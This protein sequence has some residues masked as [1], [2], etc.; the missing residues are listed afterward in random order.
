MSVLVQAYTRRRRSL[1]QGGGTDWAMAF[2]ESGVTSEADSRVL[3]QRL[4]VLSEELCP[5]LHGSLRNFLVRPFGGSVS[6]ESGLLTRAYVVQ[7]GGA[8]TS[9]KVLLKLRHADWFALED[10][11]GVF[12]LIQSQVCAGDAEFLL[13]CTHTS[14]VVIST[15]ALHSESSI[16]VAELF[17]GGFAGWSQAAY[18]LHRAGL[19]LHLKWSLDVDSDCERMLQVQTP[20]LQCIN[21]ASELDHVSDTSPSAL[22]VCANLNWDWWLRMF[23]IRPVHIVTL[24]PPCQPWSAAGTGSGLDAADGLLL[25]RAIDI[26]GAFQTP[27]VALEQVSGFLHHAH[28]PQIMQAWR[29]AGYQVQWQASL[30]LLDVLPSSRVRLIMVFRHCTCHGP[31]ALAGIN[32]TVAQRQNLAMAKVIFDLPAEL[33]KPL[34]LTEEQK[35]VYFDPWYLP[36]SR[37]GSQHPQRVENFRVRTEAGV[38]GCFLAQYQFQHELPE[39]QLASKGLLGFLLRHKGCLRFFAGA[40]VAAVHGAVRPVWL[41]DDRRAQM[42]MLGNAIAVPHAAAGLAVACRAL[43]RPNVP[44]PPAAVAKCLE[45]RIRND[46]A[47]FLP[48]GR[49]WVLCRKD[50][51]AEVITSGVIPQLPPQQPSAPP[52]FATVSLLQGRQTMTIRVPAGAPALRV[53]R[54]LGV[55]QYA[56][57]LPT[58]VFDCLEDVSLHVPSLPALHNQGF[59]AEAASQD[60][61]CTVLAPTAM[62]VVDMASPRLWPQ[63]LN[64]FDSLTSDCEE[65]CCWSPS[66]CRI[67][68][69]EDFGPCVVATTQ[70]SE[71][72]DLPMH[73]L[74]GVLPRMCE[75]QSEGEVRLECP[76]SAAVDAWLGFPFHLAQAFGWQSSVFNFP[77]QDGVP[78]YIGLQP[79]QLGHLPH[80]QLPRQIRLWYLVALLDRQSSAAASPPVNVE[81]QVDSHRVWWGT[82]PDSLV[83]EEVENWWEAVSLACK[84]PPGARVFSGPHPIPSGDTIADV[85]QQPKACVVRRSGHLLLTIHPNCVGGGVK[86]ENQHWAQTRAASL[87]LSQGLDLTATTN[88]VDAIAQKGSVPKLMQCLQALAEDTRW[89]QLCAYA[90]ELQIPVPATTNLVARAEGRARRAF[91][92]K[93]ANAAT[94]PKAAEVTVDPG[95]FLNADDT[96]APIL[97]HIRPGATG[98]LLVDPDQAVDAL[99]T[100]KGVQP[101]ELGLLVLGHVC[102]DSSTCTRRVSFPATSRRCGSKLLLAGCLHN[103]GGKAIRPNQKSDITV[104][105]PATTC[106]VF[107]AFADEFAA[108]AW[109]QLVLAPV[110]HMLAAFQDCPAVKAVLTPWGRQFRLKDRPSSP[111][112]ADQVSFQA[113]LPKEE[114]EALLTASGHNSIYVTPKQLDGNLVAGYAVIWIGPQR[115][116]AVKAAL[117]I[118]DQRGLVR[119]K[120]RYGLRVAESRFAAVFGQLRPGQTAPS[121]IAVSH[122]YRVGPVPQSADAQALATW[123]SK[124]GWT[125]KVLKAL[126]PS[127]WL[128]GSSEEPPLEWPLFNGQTILVNKVQQRTAAAPV[129]QS[130]SFQT[131]GPAPDSTS[132]KEAKSGEDPWLVSDPWSAAR[133]LSSVGNRSLQTRSPSAQSAATGRAVTG[134]IEQRFQQQDARMQALEEGMQALKLQQEQ[135]HQQLVQQQTADRQAA[136]QATA[137]LTEQLSS[138]GTELTRQLQAS[139]TALQNAQQHQQTQM[140]TSLDELKALFLESRE[141]RAACKKQKHDEGDGL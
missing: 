85:R 5:E 49:G 95:F 13:D 50:Q 59:P 114:C 9:R 7:H 6:T 43:G 53:F 125:V 103:I 82:L 127:H 111:S 2:S 124:F 117:Q 27:V 139:A 129:I 18:I 68:D 24:S 101:D 65:L 120:G 1:P 58:H 48:C 138:V 115:A 121:R 66:G 92:K 44:E 60:G 128:L 83:V 17:S 4:S 38:A 116:D 73:L 130:G 26:L 77:P 79:S 135:G 36:P 56:S 94:V 104:E 99:N 37:T 35:L 54:H 52:D 32:W 8:T 21:Q 81:V 123:A 78:M 122:L 19:P 137:T 75:P 45:A 34:L 70:A 126:G 51:A 76:A 31:P 30:D 15:A 74:A 112:L 108:E 109:A 10:P 89:Q 41:G 22:H 96:A 71:A 87:C 113:R 97:E 91:Q 23:S 64:V 28:F 47:L 102:P 119:A 14:A 84:L 141:H 93:R 57:M 67:R 100:L 55:A 110:K 90:R 131:T 3:W 105:L 61:L 46:N 33:I 136:A 42:R 118:Q 107:T 88:F 29:Q 12:K 80:Q 140:Q 134:P 62:F 86:D 63:L 98:L 39:G 132:S 16:C 69:A 11:T 72:P 25:L 133:S 106:C 40:E 20:G